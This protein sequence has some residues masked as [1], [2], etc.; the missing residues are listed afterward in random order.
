MRVEDIVSGQKIVRMA[1]DGW[2]EA[3]AAG[4][5]TA[6]AAFADKMLRFKGLLRDRVAISDERAASDEELVDF[7]AKGDPKKAAVLRSIIGSSDEFD[8][9]GSLH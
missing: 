2:Q 9:D 6:A 5:W 3:A 7:L 8:D 4:N 1:L